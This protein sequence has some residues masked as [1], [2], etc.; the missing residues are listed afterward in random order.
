MCSSHASSR[1]CCVCGYSGS[2][3][4]QSCERRC[5]L[6][7]REMAGDKGSMHTG[8]Q[9]V[10]LAKNTQPWAHG[11]GLPGCSRSESHGAREHAP[12]CQGLSKAAQP[13]RVLGSKG[14]PRPA[15]SCLPSQWQGKHK[16]T[17]SKG[18]LPA[19]FLPFLRNSGLDAEGP[20]VDPGPPKA[21]STPQH[22]V[23]Q[24][25]R[26]RGQGQGSLTHWHQG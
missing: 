18:S 23:C 14:L 17:V 12:V 1:C 13:P 8:E 11:L 26:S 21:K 16:N 5:S 2:P 15:P 10:P 24:T 6:A 3:G 9:P 20:P 7:T 25:T 22:P 19:I 4:W